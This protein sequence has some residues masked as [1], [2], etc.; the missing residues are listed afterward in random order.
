MNFY[1]FNSTRTQIQYLDI[2]K[3]GAYLHKRI[4]LVLGEAQRSYNL[5]CSVVCY[6][7][8]QFSRDV[9]SWDSQRFVSSF[10]AF[11][12]LVEHSLI[13]GFLGCKFGQLAIN[14]ILREENEILKQFESFLFIFLLHVAHVHFAIF[15]IREDDIIIDDKLSEFLPHCLY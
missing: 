1:L 2:R 7:S 9:L 11:G 15:N 4:D 3:S 6:F 14:I 5:L 12:D 10:V 8:Q 13:E